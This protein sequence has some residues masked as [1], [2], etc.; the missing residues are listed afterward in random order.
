MKMIAKIKAATMHRNA[1][2][3]DSEKRKHRAVRH[4]QAVLLCRVLQK[5]QRYLPVP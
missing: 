1:H 5:R 3:A 4:R 2:Q